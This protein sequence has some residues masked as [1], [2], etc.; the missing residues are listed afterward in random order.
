VGI[1]IEP[2]D[3]S[4]A[5]VRAWLA[6]C[7]PP[8]IGAVTRFHRAA[9]I[10]A[11]HPARTARGDAREMLPA[12]LDGIPDGAMPC[13]VDSYVH[14]F[15]PIDELRR[16]R[17]LVDRLGGEREL[18]WISLDPLVPM[19]PK[20]SSSVLGIPV[21]AAIVDRNRREGV[22]GVLGR[23]A[24]RDGQRSGALLALAHPGAAWMEWLEAST[25]G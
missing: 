25:P 1:D 12:A 4:D 20:A 13:L 19:G 15:F 17:A 23:L 8:E 21:P 24:Y 7:V 16:F 5:E 10:A 22:F 18:D 3:L 2:L 11:G 6:A 14:V 9:E